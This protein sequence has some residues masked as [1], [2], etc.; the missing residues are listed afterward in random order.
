VDVDFRVLGPMDARLGDTPL[1]LGAPK[2]RTALA[3]LLLHRNQPVTLRRVVDELW[4]L[5]AP[6]SG[7]ANAISYLSRLRRV[8][9][10]AGCT[11]ERR[12]GG[13]VL[14]VR[15]D[16]VD[17]GRFGAAA[18]IGDT[19][20]SAGEPA[21]AERH[22]ARALAAWRGP[23]F[24][25]LPIGPELDAARAQLAERRLTV[26]ERHARARLR[27]GGGSGTVSDLRRHVLA[28]P[29]RESGWLLL[30]AASWFAGNPAAALATY[31]EARSVLAA[32]LGVDPGPRLRAMHLAVLTDDDDAGWE[33]LD[34]AVHR[35]ASGDRPARLPAV[36]AQLP[37][38]VRGFAGRTDQLARLDAVVDSTVTQPTA[39]VI[40]AVSGTAGV[41][42]T[43][44]ALHWA[45]LR[46]DRFPDG[47]LY[48]NLRGFDPD[49]APTDPA[50]VV[51]GFLDALGVPA[52]RVPDGADT[53]GALYRSLM[54]GRRMLVVLDNGRDAD[55]VRPLLPGSPTCVVLVTSRNR[56]ADLVAING[57]QPLP[58]DLLDPAEAL[59]LLANRLGEAR[60]AAEPEAAEEIVARC[61]RLPLALSIVGARAAANPR[62]PLTALAGQ[63]RDTDGT[64]DGLAGD[65]PLA[66]VRTVFSWSF[67]HLG[68]DAARLFRLLGRQPGPDLDALAAASLAGAPAPAVRPLLAEL[69]R[70]NLLIE[71]V[72]GRY[73]LHD[74]LR[75]YAGELSRARDNDLDSSAAERRLLDH[76][77]HTA[78]AAARLIV[79]HRDWDPGQDPAPGTVL[80]RLTS[81]G[82]A[83]D[84]FA[85]ERSTLVAA[86][87]TA[88]AHGYDGHTRQ[89]A[90]ATTVYFA[91]QGHTA[92]WVATQL[93]AVDA[94]VRSADL[95]GQAD[96][97]RA[98]LRAYSRLGRHTEARQHFDRAIDLFSELGD[99]V[100]QAHTHINLAYAELVRGRH[101]DALRH[102]QLA[103][104]LYRAAGDVSGQA[105][106]L[107]SLG[108]AHSVLGNHRQTLEH[109]DQALTLL[110]QIGASGREANA[111]DSIGHAHHHLGDHG[112]ALASFEA[113]L[114][115]SRG[116]GDR[117][118]E[119]DV[120]VHLGDTR[121]AVGDRGA[122]RT[123]WQDALAV[124][125]DIG[126]PDTETVKAR[127]HDL[128]TA[129]PPP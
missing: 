121:L 76:Y 12:T 41:G 3:L 21:A 96:A 63:L 45:H 98:L 29:L 50:K 72:P 94:A 15:A 49:G 112:K 117:Y 24:D 5:S 38:D 101:R 1:E 79:P 118:T 74:L 58:L 52:W 127:L 44:L 66:D 13:Y 84:W 100:S 51:R 46:A 48:V 128:L 115:I 18:D 83:M 119:A 73:T 60:V 7:A 62:F 61:A 9:G 88:A 107:N 67:R 122:A 64:L 68:D 22:W 81:R 25:G 93:A 99:V 78:C 86:I 80:P 31:E 34:D 17:L 14:H 70:A 43:A 53:Q 111:L 23:A 87:E 26:L 19:A 124:M 109:C 11:L 129:E 40:S 59:Q 120:L 56:L 10:D 28:E 108:W 90:A 106:A 116:G 42:K 6:S 33:L 102:D 32:Q 105:D 75:V 97:H 85:T 47:Q 92:E 104:D 4:P 35:P 69:T 36:P 39:V 77:L 30:M 37:L 103:L 57:A 65:G 114:A 123:T 110:R 95:R 2:Q 16:A 91:R 54:A 20:W 125:L 8:L 89:L 71:H 27:L 82:Q 113:A 126:H 55:Q